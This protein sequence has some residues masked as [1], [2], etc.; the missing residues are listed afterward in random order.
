M[1]SSIIFLFAGAFFCG[2]FVYAVTPEIASLYSKANKYL[3]SARVSNALSTFEKV[4]MYQGGK[5]DADDYF[6]KI[7]AAEKILDIYTGLNDQEKIQTSCYLI[8]S[9]YAAA[10]EAFKKSTNLTAFQKA[11]SLSKILIDIYGNEGNY[12][13]PSG[14]SYHLDLRTIGRQDCASRLNYYLEDQS[15]LE[16]IYWSN[17]AFT[18][19]DKLSTMDARDQERIPLEKKAFEYFYRIAQNNPNSYMSNFQLAKMLKE[20]MGTDRDLKKAMLYAEKALILASNLSEMH[21]AQE[22]QREIETRQ[23][24]YAG[25]QKYQDA[26]EE[27]DPARHDAIEQQALEILEAAHKGDPNKMY[28]LEFTLAQIY[29]NKASRDKRKFSEKES[30]IRMA[31]V[32]LNNA[33]SL[34]LT[35]AQKMSVEDLNKKLSGMVGSALRNSS[36]VE[37]D[38]V[39]RGLGRVLGSNPHLSK[40]QRSSGLM[41]RLFGS[42]AKAEELAGQ[43]ALARLSKAS[44][45]NQASS[46]K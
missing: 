5:L 32:H 29:Y 1:K 4:V 31:N 8:I 46:S 7:D 45:Q 43:K 37:D 22:M 21:N 39:V 20:G 16:E 25:L 18:I 36:A 34:A 24:L 33:R 44:D 41:T 13:S 14:K 9:A 10:Y 15:K 27:T 19:L 40:P 23:K 38:G 12:V 30:T 11:R 26:Q 6:I 42:P 3:N 2:G 28:L 17:E 35:D